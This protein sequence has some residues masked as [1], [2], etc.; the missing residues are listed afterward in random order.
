MQPL[1]SSLFEHQLTSYDWYSDLIIHS[2]QKELGL[3]KLLDLPVHQ[4]DGQHQFVFDTSQLMAALS[5]E[6]ESM[7]LRD[8]SR[9]I[10]KGSGEP[11]VGFGNSGNDAVYNLETFLTCESSAIASE[12]PSRTPTYT[13]SNR[14]SSGLLEARNSKSI[15]DKQR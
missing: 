8:M 7:S 12:T 9:A 11:I 6:Y 2:A 4:T 1:V 5:D 14:V 13:C 10:L 15:H 3:Y